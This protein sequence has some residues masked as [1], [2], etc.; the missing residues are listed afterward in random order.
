MQIEDFHFLRPWWLLSLLPLLMFAWY[1]VKRT[2]S[3]SGWETTIDDDLLAVLLDGAHKRTNR[4]LS[5]L[6]LVAFT[7]SAVGLAGP[8]WQKL[9]QNVEQKNDALVIILDLSLSMLAEDIK[10]SRIERARQEITDVL[11]LREEGQT[12]LVA[13]AGDAH[14]V[15]PLTNDTATITNLLVSL[16]PEMMP[17]FGSK[18][19]HALTLAH[20]LFDNALIQQGRILLVTDGIDNI[21][22]VTRH[23]SRAFPISV[24]GIGSAQGG[25]IPL[26]RIRQPGR[27][28]QTQ[29]GN[30]I[31]ALLDEQ[32]LREVANLSYGNYAKAIVGDA[33]ITYALAVPL[34]SEDDSIEVEREF[35]TWFD[36]GHWATLLLI[37]LLL[38]GFRKGVFLCLLLTCSLAAPPAHA[39]AVTD[40]WHSLW[41]RG[42]QRG[43]QALRGGEPEKAATLFDDRQWQSVAQYRSG[44]YIS[45]LTGFQSN[46]GVT[47]RYNEANSLARLSEYGAAITLYQQ[48]LSAQPN[49]QDATFNKELVERLLQEQQQAEQQQNQDQQNQAN[50]ENSDSEQNDQSEDQ[51]QSD[52]DQDSEQ[53]DQEQQ[54]ESTSEQENQQGDEQQMAEAEQDDATR[55][56]KREALEQWLRRVPDDP[57]GL[58]RRKFSHETKQRLRRGEFENRQGEKLW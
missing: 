34:P 57:G 44:D 51:E 20:E 28:L 10:P 26:D 23:R 55:D 15:V 2:Q 50:N 25:P 19:D 49:H 18:T 17:V 37:P 14:A 46:P 43:F 9:P 21:N 32:R 11:R 8:T 4:W 33:D 40:L 53:S 29:E 56:E 35:D 58:L 6:L 13:Y 7:C 16:S 22:S 52:Q 30:Q 3:G 31:I 24:L 54:D 45:S 42:D 39:N 47:G 5:F 1:W 12:A 41:S 38:L 27:F 48:V 36:Q